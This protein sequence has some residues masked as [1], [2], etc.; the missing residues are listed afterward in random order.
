M[1]T[2]HNSVKS[3]GIAVTLAIFLTALFSSFFNIAYAKE[4]HL[5]IADNAES[6]KPLQVGDKAPKFTVKDTDGEQVIFDPNELDSP[7]LIVVYRGGWCPYCNVQL[8]D[9]RKVLPEIREKGVNVMFLSGDRPEI[10]YSG[11]KEQ[12]QEEIDGL[13]YKIYSDADM[14]ASSALGIAFNSSGFGMTLLKL[15]PSTSGSSL[16]KHNALPVPAVF[17]INKD[18]EVTY[19]FVDP[20]FKV[21]LPAEDVLAAVDTAL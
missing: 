19:S 9:L 10:L 15:K 7:T 6:I 13:D 5:T 2:V 20:N 17:V 11:L 4:T 8:Q 14:E 18:G 12:T 16:R 21:R 1:G 3:A